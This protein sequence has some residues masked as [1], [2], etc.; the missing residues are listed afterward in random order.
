MVLN[1]CRF[2]SGERF[3]KGVDTYLDVRAS[4]LSLN[5]E[6]FSGMIFVLCGEGKNADVKAMTES[7]LVALADLTDEEMLGIYCAA[8][9]YVNF[10]R[11]EG[12][13]R[14][15]RAG[16]GN[17]VANNSLRYSRPR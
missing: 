17:G 14:G 3:H 9:A 15:H 12:Y 10:S 13:N 16:L 7:G 4:I 2:H 11:W 8:D 5:P 6:M 1:V